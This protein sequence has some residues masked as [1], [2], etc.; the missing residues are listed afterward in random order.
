M[1]EGQRGDGPALGDLDPDVVEAA[2]LAHDLGHPPFGHAGEQV[3]QQVATDAGATDGFEGN[4][5]SFRIVTRLAAHN[6]KYRGLN[7]TRATLNAVLKYPWLHAQCGDPGTKADKYGAYQSDQAHFEFARGG[8]EK[9]L[10]RSLEAEIMNLADD[11]AYSV[12]DL[13]DFYRAG[14]VPI[15]ILLTRPVELEA[16]LDRWGADPKAK[17]TKSEIDVNRDLIA[18]TLASFELSEVY[19]GTFMQRAELQSRNSAILGDFVQAVQLVSRG[20]PSGYGVKLDSD[21]QFAIWFLQ[22]LVWDFVIVN[23]RLGTQQ[24]GQAEIIR[25]LFEVYLDAVKNRDPRIVPPLF[26]YEM[27][28]LGTDA[29]LSVEYQVVRL[30]VDIVASMTEDQARLLYNRIIGVGSGSITDL[31]HR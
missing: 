25:K 23:P 10:D 30:A 6:T 18:Q 2:A 27:E 13:D 17:V 24:H 15:E 31:L 16:F 8:F 20:S 3:L 29:G 19:G 14:L 11:I 1:A 26:L 12:H 9:S 22:R 28:R 21:R 7:L 4:A 5:Q